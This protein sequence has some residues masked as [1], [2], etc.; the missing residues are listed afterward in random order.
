MQFQEFKDY[1][2]TAA[3]DA[4]LTEYEIY[5]KNTVQVNVMAVSDQNKVNQFSS[6]ENGGVCFRCIVNKTMGYASTEYFSL[7]EAKKLVKKAMENA[8]SIETEDEIELHKAEE[9]YETAHKKHIEFPQ[10][11][12]LIEKTLQAQREA[13]DADK[14][15]TGGT[16]TYSAAYTTTEA[17]C[18][19]KGLDLSNT[20]T[21]SELEV[22]PVIAEKEQMYSSYEVKISDWDFL[23]A[24]ETANRAVK[25]GIEKIG[26][27]SI[28]SGTYPVVFSADQMAT[29]LGTF[30]SI[31]SA[32]NAQKGLSLLIKKEGEPI[33]SKLVTIT[34][35]PFYQD[36][37][38]TCSFDA[39][40]AATK[41]KT[42]IEKGEFKTLLYNWQTAKK[43]GVKTT[44]NASKASYSSPISIMPYN[45]FLNAGDMT[46]EELFSK[47]ENGVYITELNG[48]HAGANAVTGDFSLSA[49]GFLIKDKA[50]EKAVKNIT[51]S[52]N[53]YTLL[54]EIIGVGN[55]IEFLPPRGYS[56]F[57]SPAVLIKE[58]AIAGK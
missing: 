7:E 21:V 17:I 49:E 23:D 4:G 33:A 30:S 25:K 58:L 12:K 41:T 56:V 29:M 8:E 18:N 54:K 6:S 9:H 48:L 16:M 39:E 14:R 3:K 36:S 57:G 55:T 19:S 35:D 47:A 27:E 11:S 28:E 45:F 52:G 37:F 50:L 43:A 22:S 5:Y 10:S 40:G 2:V 53:F 24:K 51:V 26:A 38:I 15:V 44:G 42:V 1:V 32:E 46:L 31:F 13:L 20:I 34:D